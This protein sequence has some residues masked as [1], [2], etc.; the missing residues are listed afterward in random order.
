MYMYIY[1]EYA[2]TRIW[3]HVKNGLA[4]IVFEINQREERA[5]TDKCIMF[6]VAPLRTGSF[7]K[8]F[9]KYSIKIP[10]KRRAYM[11]TCIHPCASASFLI[12]RQPKDAIKTR[13][14]TASRRHTCRLYAGCV[15]TRKHHNFTFNAVGHAHIWAEGRGYINLSGPFVTDALDTPVEFIH[16]VGEPVNSGY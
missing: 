8:R 7:C 9:V 1:V 5:S 13:L 16:R 4:K 10:S 12:V 3:R 2:I 14:S 6:I 11:H 15:I